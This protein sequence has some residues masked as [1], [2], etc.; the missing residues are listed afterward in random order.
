[1]KKSI[2]FLI[3]GLGIEK[4]K[5][6]SISIDQ[7][8]PNLARAKETSYFT[9]AFIN[10]LEPTGAYLQFFLGDTHNYELNFLKENIINESLPN[11][12]TYQ[13]FVN[14]ISK[15]N[16]KLHVFVEPTNEKI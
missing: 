9:T 11:N 12:P 6:Y 3:N 1:M 14:S 16:T 5:S 4:P 13:K 15:P 8:M 10:S 2:I 7:S